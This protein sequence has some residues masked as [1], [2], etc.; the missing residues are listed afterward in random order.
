MDDRIEDYILRHS[1]EE[2]IEPAQSGN[3]CKIIKTSYVVGA[4]AGA[5]T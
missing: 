1:D 2:G 4:F 3:P 5:Y